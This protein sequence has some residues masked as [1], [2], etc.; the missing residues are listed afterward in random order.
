M[1]LNSYFPSLGVISNSVHEPTSILDVSVL[2]YTQGIWGLSSSEHSSS[3]VVKFIENFLTEA[4]LPSACFELKTSLFL[5]NSASSEGSFCW[6]HCLWLAGL[7]AQIK[8]LNF[9]RLCI[10]TSHYT[11]YWNWFFRHKD[12]LTPIALTLFLC[13]FPCLRY[14]PKYLACKHAQ[15]GINFFFSKK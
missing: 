8:N 13:C 9:C 7:P 6:P 11:S 5:P 2:G 1:L 10:N 4:G 3:Q 12:V 14:I 15:N